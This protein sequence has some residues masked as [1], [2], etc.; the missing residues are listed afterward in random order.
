MSSVQVNDLIV[1]FSKGPNNATFVF[2]SFP[3]TTLRLNS[4]NFSRAMIIQV[5]ILLI[6]EVDGDLLPEASSSAFYSF[7]HLFRSLEIH[8]SYFLNA[9][10]YYVT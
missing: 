6:E 5:R 9:I 1:L 8:L 2:F 3:I 7:C 10:L 4:G